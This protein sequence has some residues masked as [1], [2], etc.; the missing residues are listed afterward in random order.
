MIYKLCEDETE[1]LSERQVIR[2]GQVRN[3]EELQLGRIYLVMK[4]E[5]ARAEKAGLLEILALG[6]D[7]PEYIRVRHLGNGY[8]SDLW[9]AEYGIVPFPSRKWE[10]SRYLIPAKESDILSNENLYVSGNGWVFGSIRALL[11]CGEEDMQKLLHF[12]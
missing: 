10:L 6:T 11:R 12:S 2:D 9:L 4:V 5:E 1:E 3:E 7:K 8:E